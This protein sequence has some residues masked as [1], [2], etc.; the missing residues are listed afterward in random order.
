MK[1]DLMSEADWPG[2]AAIY[3][4]GIATGHATF[5]SA[6]P[7]SFAE[8]SDGKL[9]EC[10]LAA[11]DEAEKILGWATLSKV[12]DRCVYAGV[13]E[14]SVYVAAA[15]RGA[16]VGAGLLG[17]LIARS[18][19]AGVWTLQAGI[20]PENTASIALHER[21]DFRLLGRRERVGKMMFG[22][23]AG[24]WRDTLLFERRSTVAGVD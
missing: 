17:E 20:F 18:E 6:P 1:L 16:K 19:A 8:F 5:A 15:A 10:A 4:E 21:F 12:S 3:R 9:R 24:R 11:R 7:D 23:L 2:V 14:V 13:A 22:P